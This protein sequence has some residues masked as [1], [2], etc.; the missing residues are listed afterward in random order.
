MSRR[1][2]L[3]VGTP[4]SGTS[5]LQ[6]KLALNRAVLEQ[7]GLDYLQTRRGTHFEPAL[8]LIGVRWAGEEKAARGQWDAL[9][10]EARKA[11]RDV[12]VSHEILAAATPASVARA[13][14][15]FPDHEVH[16]VVTARDLGRQIPA[17]WQEKVKHRGRRTFAEFLKALH[18][19]YPGD[20][21]KMWFWKVQHLPRILATW[22]AGL[23]PEQ[24]HLVTVPPSGAP[25]DL[26]WERFS[27]VLGLDPSVAY[28]ESETTNASLGGPEVT[29]LRR[30][31]TDL[32]ERGVPRETYVEWVRE[33]IVKDVLAQ[34]PEMVPTTVPPRRRPSV[35]AIVAGWIEEI[36]ASGIDVVGDL[37][38]LLPVWPAKDVRWTNPDN[39]D[40][41]VVADLAIESLVHVLGEIGSPAHATGPV[42]RLARRLRG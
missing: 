28:A 21:P 38:D 32:A 26:L 16:V 40:P 31:N 35:D 6:D 29:L 25:G 17:E 2:Y 30:L 1:V 18:R 8:D 4:K 10:L 9:V 13:M 36:R 33:T 15:S 14:A 12:L 24:V 39:A 22:G 11:R 5:F 34:R 41:A 42:A 37:D 20:E 7:Q 19:S 27:G 23:P 3:H